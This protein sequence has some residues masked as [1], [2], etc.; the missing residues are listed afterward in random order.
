MIAIARAHS[1][2]S[3]DDWRECNVNGDDDDVGL[4]SSFASNLILHIKIHM[5]VELFLMLFFFISVVVVFHTIFIGK[6]YIPSNG[7]VAMSSMWVLCVCVFFSY[8]SLHFRLIKFELENETLI[9]IGNL[10]WIH[11]R[12]LKTSWQT[13]AIAQ[14][15]HTFFN[16]HNCCIHNKHWVLNLLVLF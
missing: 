12:A 2:K 6:I 7:H 10:F 9:R 8:F 4:C 11:N 5:Y 16:M 1:Q 14:T 13:H 3:L 15:T